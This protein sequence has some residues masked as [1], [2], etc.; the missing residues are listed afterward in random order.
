MKHKEHHHH[1]PPKTVI[2]FILVFLLGLFIVIF[3]HPQIWFDPLSDYLTGKLTQKLN[4]DLTIHRVYGNFNQG[5]TV[6]SLTLR[7]KE[8]RF[9]FTADRIS[10]NYRNILVLLVTRSVDSLEIMNPVLVTRKSQNKGPEN[11]MKNEV[12]V[13]KI[14]T[15]LNK[16]P[17]VK[18]R[19]MF[20]ENGA[21]LQAEEG[22][23]ERIAE[24]IS[25]TF[26]LNTRGGKADVSA[27]SLTFHLP[28]NGWETDSLA[29]DI[30]YANGLLKVRDFLLC[31]NKANFHLTGKIQPMPDLPFKGEVLV[32]NITPPLIR[33]FSSAPWTEIINRGSGNVFDLLLTFSG[34]RQSV[35][36]DFSIQGIFMDEIIDQCEGQLRYR[37]GRVEM[38]R[39]SFQNAW[40]KAF[41]SKASYEDGRFSLDADLDQVNIPL[42]DSPFS[43]FTVHGSFATG[44]RLPD[45]VAVQYHF[46]GNLGNRLPV[47]DLAG[48]FLYQDNHLMLTDTN[49]VR[50]PGAMLDITGRVDSLKDLNI[51]FSGK[52]SG[53]HL[54]EVLPESLTVDNGTLQGRLKGVLQDPDLSFIYLLNQAQYGSHTLARARGA[55]SVKQ[56]QTALSGNFYVDFSELNLRDYRF[57]GGGAFL[58]FL[59]DTILISSLHLSAGEN[60]M[61]LVGKAGMDS[62]V[63]IDEF[64]ANIQDNSFYLIEPFQFDFKTGKV[65]ITP[66]SLRFNEG[67]FHAQGE[68][69]LKNEIHFNA[70]GENLNLS[71]L[72]SLWDS[73]MQ[74]EGIMNFSVD[75]SGALSNPEIQAQ[76]GVEDFH[77]EDYAFQ[78]FSATAQLADSVLTLNKAR[79][80]QG[81]KSY[82]NAFGRFPVIL[83]LDQS[84]G[85]RLPREE[86]FTFT[87]EI[88][89][90]ALDVLTELSP[91]IQH[92]GGISDGIL[93]GRGTY[94]DPEI[95]L[96][97][98]IEDFT[99]N[100]FGFKKVLSQLNY[101]DEKILIKN[102][103]KA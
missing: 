21:Y 9:T 3:F 42:E 15:A 62:L 10:V 99:L 17:A 91:R 46:S 97:L 89:Q 93:T 82:L 60:R 73:P 48:R 102:I 40:G 75:A 78:S 101:Q 59:Q 72:F 87:T 70:S 51:M 35:R 79:F 24:Q 81:E 50:I 11:T 31:F 65:R 80:Q 14:E 7:N 8:E 16:I 30:S 22:K 54:K 43:P 76:W 1:T 68:S 23:E 49:R 88:H 5:V 92:I 32:Q 20:L 58:E 69:D 34:N 41:I 57:D 103:N 98:T 25:G 61:E 96:N 71:E 26:S 33:Q 56:L 19:S 18:I 45:S 86:S 37:T 2:P 12:T 100:Q 53:F 52:L 94:Q 66:L 39:L 74:T 55:A 36:T 38:N 44:G 67:V 13:G 4:A 63:M 47:D 85:I 84:P 83:T 95:N 64:A 6:D 90:T 28:G 27:Q 77:V 29:F